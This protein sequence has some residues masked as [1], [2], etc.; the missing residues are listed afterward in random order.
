MDYQNNSFGDTSG[1][2]VMEMSVQ[3]QVNGG[4]TIGISAGVTVNNER[5]VSGNIM[6]T[7][8]K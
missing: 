4:R 8:T 2:D 3:E 6:V 1:F 5:E 7:I